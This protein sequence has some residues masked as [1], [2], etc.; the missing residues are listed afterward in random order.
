VRRVLL[1][2]FA[3]FLLSTTVNL[4]AGF[5]VGGQHGPPPFWG[6]FWIVF[7]GGALMVMWRF[8]NRI[9]SPFGDVMGALDRLAA[10]DYTARVEPGGPPPMRALGDALNTTATRLAAAEEQRRNLVADIAHE[11]RTPL[12]VIRGN[13]EGMLDGLYPAEPARLA[14]ILDEVAV[15]TRLVEDLGTLSSAEAG[16]LQLHRAPTD[17][18]GLARDVAASFEAQAAAAGVSLAVTG[19]PATVDVDEHRVRQVLENIVANA[20]R[21][22]PAG[23]SVAIQVT[24][25]AGGAVVAVADT[26]SGIAPD[27][28]PHIFERY[29]KSPNSTGSGLGLAI[30]RSLVEAHGGAITATS[31]PGRGTTISFTLPGE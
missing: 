7:L 10:G 5:F 14:P 21:H 16:V 17:L 11:V 22:T 3:F 31:E 24:A 1:V 6:L 13:V 9:T 20:I 26:G 4:V 15:I 2:L 19:E 18:A 28:L 23:G 12:A 29:R 27:D 8:A 30:A 25:E